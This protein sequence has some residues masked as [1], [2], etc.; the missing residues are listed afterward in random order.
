M[1]GD[2]RLPLV[3][4]STSPRRRE[5]LQQAGFAFE[6]IPADIEEAEGPGEAPDALVRRLARDKA[7]AVAR[8]LGPEP[9][10]RVLGA[11]TLVVLDDTVLGKPADALQAVCTLTRLAGRTHRV[12]TG[13]A[14]VSSRGLS[15]RQ[16]HVETRVRMRAADAEEIRAYVASGEP[17]DKAGAYAAQGSGRR[18]IEEIVGSESNVIGLPLDE[19]VE[20]LR[21]AGVPWR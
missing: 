11:D 14:L 15:V 16:C 12:L 2:D 3:L 5:L 9:P 7:L 17:M 10:R 21:Q 1:D 6:V 19:T 18:F 4:A 8:R 13:V 20:L